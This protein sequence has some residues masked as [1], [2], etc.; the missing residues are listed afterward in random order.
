MNPTFAPQLAGDMSD[1]KYGFMFRKL[2]QTLLSPVSFIS[3]LAAGKIISP[4]THA[5]KYLTHRHTNNI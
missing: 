3:L 5:Q 1:P 2:S 4:T